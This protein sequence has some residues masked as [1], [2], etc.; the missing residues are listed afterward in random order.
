MFSVSSEKQDNQD[1]RK[2]LERRADA[3]AQKDLPRYLSCFSQTYRSDQYQYADLQKNAS[4]WFAQFATI[5]FS[6]RILEIQLR[7]NTAIVENDYTFSLTDIDGE[8]VDIAKREL[9]EIKRED[10]AWKI[11]SSLT[12]Q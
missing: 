8:S 11:T 9:L 3:L 6:F 12:I 10:N 7:D 2:L 5:R 4:R 1:I